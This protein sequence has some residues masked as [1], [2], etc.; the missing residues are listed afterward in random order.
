LK[1]YRK[2]IE[3]RVVKN[4]YILLPSYDGSYNGQTILGES[5]V[6]ESFDG[7]VAYLRYHLEVPPDAIGPGLK[8]ILNDK[9]L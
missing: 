4:G 2:S 8:E 3:I 5:F 7:M 6:F 1:T 9:S